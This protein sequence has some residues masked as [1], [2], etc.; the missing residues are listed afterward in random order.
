MGKNAE[1]RAV[2]KASLDRYSRAK[3]GS[4]I[5]AVVGLVLVSLLTLTFHW[6]WFFLLVAP[7]FASMLK[8]DRLVIWLRRF[9][10]DDAD[11]YPFHRALLASSRLLGAVPV[12]PQDSRFTHSSA[13]ALGRST[14]LVELV[15]AGIL[16]ALK[17][18]LPILLLVLGAF[19]LLGGESGAEEGSTFRLVV[20]V[21][22][23]G[24][25]ALGSLAMSLLSMRRKLVTQG[26]VPLTES[27]A[28]RQVDTLLGRIQAGEVYSNGVE[29]LRCGESFWQRIV[30]KGMKRADAVVID[31]TRPSEWVLW[32][33]STAFEVAGDRVI[34]V[35]RD[36]DGELPEEVREQLLEK[37]SEAELSR[38]RVVAYRAQD[39]PRG[40]V[41]E[42][43]HRQMLTAMSSCFAAEVD[44]ERSG[45]WTRNGLKI[46]RRSMTWLLSVGSLAALI[47]LAFGR[48][49]TEYAADGALNPASDM[50]PL[51]V[52]LGLIHVLAGVRL[53]GYLKSWGSRR[54]LRTVFTMFLLGYLAVFSVRA[55]FA[56]AK[57]KRGLERF[58]MIGLLSE[59]IE[60]VDRMTDLLNV[61]GE[62]GEAIREDAEKVF[63]QG[64]E[65][66]REALGTE[67]L[68][69]TREQLIEERERLYDEQMKDQDRIYAELNRS[70]PES[71]Q[72][73]P[74]ELPRPD[75][76][77]M[78]DQE[79]EMRRRVGMQLGFTAD[80]TG[81][82]DATATAPSRESTEA[83]SDA[84]P[85]GLKLG[86]SFW[87]YEDADSAAAASEPSRIHKLIARVGDDIDTALYYVGLAG[88]IQALVSWRTNRGLRSAR[89]VA[90]ELVKSR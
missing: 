24:I 73:E 23:L 46:W 85:E 27:G 47:L 57:L 22:I 87:S 14:I 90:G 5:Y 13:A 40:E 80:D 42:N 72:I 52:L 26:F 2:L 88:L 61:E 45:A 82:E 29:V 4:R 51:L 83:R 18:G 12:T 9:H 86:N 30:L 8:G 10:E 20:L 19:Y 3:R 6:T 28:D 37:V 89:R 53:L 69:P 43:L 67:L 60:G 39:G 21:A 63:Q 70:L 34:L 76:E 81:E 66:A 48:Q 71:Q 1:L 44:A 25:A 11:Q 32:E 75:F 77:A 58:P 62:G 50:R 74:P 59:N 31:V 49:A 65:Q 38:A 7:V 78:V 15:K 16:G 54:A 64:I 84:P 41:R 35:H 36:A 33:L 55:G 56:Y 79:L 68:R 17:I